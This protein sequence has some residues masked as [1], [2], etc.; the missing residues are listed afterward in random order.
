MP[1]STIT[2]GYATW[3]QGAST[4]VY[5]N[6]PGQNGAGDWTWYLGR[7][8]WQY[9]N[10]FCAAYV[11]YSVPFTPDSTAAARTI[12]IPIT[13]LYDSGS[14]TSLYARLS[15]TNPGTTLSNFT[16]GPISGAFSN[17]I[18]WNQDTTTLTFTLNTGVSIS[19]KTIYLYLY[20]KSNA[21]H[22]T[23]TVTSVGNATFN[24]SCSHSSTSYGGTSG[25]HK[26]CNYCGATISTSHSYTPSVQTAATCT[27]KGTTKYTCACGYSYTSQDIPALGHNSVYGG[28]ANV[29]TKCS[30]C[31]GT[32]T[33]SGSHSYSSSV[34]TAAT[35]TTKGT[36]KYS[37]ACGYSYTSQNIPAKGHTSVNGGTSGVHT[38]C[39]VCGATLSTAHTY[40]VDSGVQYSAATCTAKRKNYLRCSCGYNPKST[41]YLVET[42]NINSS[43]HTGSAVN[44]GTANV[45]TKYSC[46]GA[47]ISSTHTYN[48]DSG[49]QY[50]AATCTTKR[51]NYL[52]CSCGYNPKSASYVTEVGSVNA[53]NHTGSIV[54]GGTAGVHTKYSCCGATVSTTH[55]YTK[56]VQTPATCTAKGTSKYT[57]SCGYSYTSQDI[58]ALGHNY[59]GTVVAPTCTAQGYTT[60]KCSRCNDTSKANDTFT[61]AI[62]HNYVGKVTTEPTYTAEGVKTYTCSNCGDSYTESIPKKQG[63]IYIN[64]GSGFKPYLV[65]IYNGS[66]W[67]LYLANI[68]NGSTWDICG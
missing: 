24:Y 15:T 55:D 29:H 63:A 67:D 16:N 61:A 39:S 34:Q 50:S 37:C 62:G 13:S 11:A 18:T 53:S 47:T 46:C 42:G 49:V 56:T 31:G 51:K 17:E 38:K 54:N 20:P 1:S 14:K 23:V 45:H 65:Y 22:Y 4:R 58:P 8:H 68:Y 10:D 36:T 48:V 66:T 57:C 43:N 6:A 5:N 41:S 2:R 26:K 40:N 60:Y 35:C 3:V 7:K 27:G 33:G 9:K 28:T 59:V 44:G 21:S 30:R 32:L 12:S 19:N 52:Q 64:D 25:V